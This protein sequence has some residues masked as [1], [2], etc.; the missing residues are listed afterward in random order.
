MCYKNNKFYR[1]NIYFKKVNLINPIYITKKTSIIYLISIG[2]I[3][4]YLLNI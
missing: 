3:L 4:V 1:L 2:V